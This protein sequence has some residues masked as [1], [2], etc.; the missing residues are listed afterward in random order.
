MSSVQLISVATLDPQVAAPKNLHK[1]TWIALTL[2]VALIY[3]AFLP[4]GI[5]SVDGNA[6]LAVAESLVTQHSFAVAPDVGVPGRGGQSFSKWYPLQSVMA[7]PFV[8]AGTEMAHAL[9]LPTHYVAAVCSLVL[10][11]LLT[12]MTTALVARISAQLGA[13]KR[14]AFLA[15][16]TYAFGTMA[17]VYARTFYAEPLLALLTAACV[18]LALSGSPAQIVWAGALAALAVLAKPT[19][20]VVGVAL[21]IY[22]FFRGTHR[23]LSLIP[24]AGSAL[25]LL[26]YFAYNQMRFGHALA[27]GQPWAFHVSGVAEGAAGLLVSPGRGL[28]WYC[29]AVVLAIAAWRK[30]KNSSALLIAGVFVG[31]LGIHSVWSFWHGGWSWGPRFLLPALPG[32]VALLGLLEGGWRRALAVLAIVG[33]LINAPTLFTFYERYYAEANER[34]VSEHDALWSF[35]EAPFLHGWS[36][37]VR[38]V[39]DAQS[40]DVRELLSERGSAPAATIG[41]SRALR[42]VAVWWWVLPVAGIPRVVGVS[43]SLVLAALGCWMVWRQDKILGN[44]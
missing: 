16:L 28:V 21:A 36:A 6:M 11:I 4:P 27:F 40:A 2:G 43:V 22:L 42:I 7:V 23:R 14:G 39:R 41:T 1:H 31:F 15:A 12:A 17:M 24:A 8:A 35:A 32:L 37:A 44:V 10:P 3:L 20:I 13:S 25:G 34:G 38:Q 29:P 5:Y 19:G 26:L 18:Y 33:F 30:I 9:R